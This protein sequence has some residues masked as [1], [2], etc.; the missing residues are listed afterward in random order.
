MN[1]ASQIVKDFYTVSLKELP[2]KIADFI[3]PDVQLLWNSSIGSVTKDFEGIYELFTTIKT[4]YSYLHCEVKEIIQQEEKVC[5]AYTYSGIPIESEEEEELLAHFMTI[6]EIKDQK[7]YR[8]Y[9]ISQKP[10]S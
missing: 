10:F 1:S 9:Q 5:I 8:G 7:L 2:K 6:W 4:S 3:H